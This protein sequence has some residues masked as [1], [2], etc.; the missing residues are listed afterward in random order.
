MTNNAFELAWKALVESDVEEKLVLS[1]KCTN[2]I[3]SGQVFFENII[4]DE[5]KP[6]R[7]EQPL[8]IDPRKLPRRNILTDEGRAAMLHSFAHI[9]FNAINLALDLICRFQDMPEVF[10]KDYGRIAL[11]ETQ[12]FSLLKN[13]LRQLGYDYGDFPAHD[14]LWQ[15]AEDTKHDILLRLGVVPRILEARGLDVTPG[16]INRFQEIKDEESVS[17]LN[18]ILEEEIGHVEAG[19]KWFRYLCDRM[20]KDSETVFKNI[21]DDFM[22]ANK[23][24]KIN[25]QARLTAGFSQTE[26]EHIISS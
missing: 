8:L 2:E 16:L 20:G 3:M 6:G 23:T 9:E 17:I 22:P 19:T 25:R 4:F 12:H 5:I 21:Y 7:P 24:N 13:R 14:G 11:E 1:T 26:L 10:Y 18:I 15:I